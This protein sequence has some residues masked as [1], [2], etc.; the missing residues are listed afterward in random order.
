MYSKCKCIHFAKGPTKA[1]ALV[2][3]I[4]IWKNLMFTAQKNPI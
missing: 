1:V 2:Y 4:I 3:M